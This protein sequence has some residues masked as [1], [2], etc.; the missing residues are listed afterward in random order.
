MDS[1][2]DAIVAA[3]QAGFSSLSLKLLPWPETVNL[4]ASAKTDIKGGL[5]LIHEGTV[6]DTSPAVV[7]IDGGGKTIPLT[8]TSQGSV[9]TVRSGVTLTLRNITFAGS[10]ANTAALIKVDGGK[11][12]L[13][14]GAVITGNTNNGGVGGGVYVNNTA[15][16]T[17]ESAVGGHT[18]G[19]IYG[20]DGGKLA[21]TA[22]SNSGHAV[23]VAG[24]GWKRDNTVKE[25]ESLDSGKNKDQG[26]GWD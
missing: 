13:E 22:T 25:D 16:F 6:S 24:N 8:G 1:A 15:S 4:D 12:I 7:I 2:I 19:T 3:Q 26:G 5:T 10:A 21:N 23:Y 17:K 11:L 14:N 18:S 9:I 20:A